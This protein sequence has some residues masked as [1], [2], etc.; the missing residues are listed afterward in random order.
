VKQVE[1]ATRWMWRLRLAFRLLDK[2]RC[3]CYGA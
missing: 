1:I 3:N 2:E